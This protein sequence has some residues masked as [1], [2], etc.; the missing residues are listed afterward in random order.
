VIA[1]CAAL[2]GSGPRPVTGAL[3][4]IRQLTKSSSDVANRRWLALMNSAGLIVY[5]QKNPT[6]KVTFNP[7]ELAPAEEA[8]ERERTSAHVL[9]PERPYSNLMALRSVLRSAREFI[10]WY[11][12][13]MPAK[14]LETLFAELDG[15]KVREVR[16][17]SGPANITAQAKGEFE[18]FKREMRSERAIGA[19]WKV[20]DKAEQSR[21][22]DRIFLTKGHAKNMPPFNTI[23]AGSVGEILASEIKPSDFEQWWKLGTDIESY[24]IPTAPKL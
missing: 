2:W 18:R 13:H 11:D 21:R 12:P 4:L 3:R 8:E 10:W 20:L 6:L 7:N 24:A 19:A 1:F 17:L 16:I 9:A 22:H 15:T 23:L 5:N 14:V